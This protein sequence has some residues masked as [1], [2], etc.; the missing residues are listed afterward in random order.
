MVE[1]EEA[2]YPIGNLRDPV[3]FE[4][5]LRHHLTG[6]EGVTHSLCQNYGMI[7]AAL[8]GDAEVLEAVVQQQFLQFQ[9]DRDVAIEGRAQHPAQRLQASQRV[10]HLRPRPAARPAA[11]ARTHGAELQARL[12]TGVRPGA[13]PPGPSLERPVVQHQRH[14]LRP[15]GHRP[16]FEH[17]IRSRAGISEAEHVGLHLGQRRSRPEAECVT[18][19]RAASESLGPEAS[20][21]L[22]LTGGLAGFST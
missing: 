5:E 11:A 4:K 22:L 17:G 21:S 16:G 12:G 1:A 13:R 18:K 14:R 19:P 9:V 3:A 2:V 15:E 6:V 10:A 7:N 20:G 8:R